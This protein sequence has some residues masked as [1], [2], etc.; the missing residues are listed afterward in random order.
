MSNLNDMMRVLGDYYTDAAILANR[1][2]AHLVADGTNLLSLN[3]I[4]GVSIAA[5]TRGEEIHAELIVREGV[6]IINPVHMCVGILAPDGA[7][8]IR[9]RTRIERHA[10]A[11]L[12][13]HCLFPNVVAARHVMNAELEMEEGAQLV[14]SEGHYHGMSGNTEVMPKARL[15]IG[16]GARYFSDFSLTSDRV[17]K[18]TLDYAVTVDE[19]A[20]AELT[21]RVFG[22]A[23]D[24]IRIRD[25]MYLNG[26]H[27]RGLIKTRVAVDGR[28]SSEVIGITHGNAEGARGHMDCMEI[29]REQAIATAEP[30]V[31][32]THPLAKIT[33]EAAVGTVDQKQLETLMAHG[34]SPEQ[35]VDMVITGMLR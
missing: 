21:A 26:K 31:K 10:S 29:V 1:Q 22:H 27:A 17:G 5:E 23:T 30:I 34:L 18:L 33:H 15:R 9:L 4:P 24:Q 25:E 6:H 14:Y 16:P 28:A 35:A 13:A 3:E 12:I 20:V 19:E 8:I 32:V 7:Q 11:R 2:T